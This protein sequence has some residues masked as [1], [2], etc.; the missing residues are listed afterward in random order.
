METCGLTEL[1]LSQH[2]A[3]SC[4]GLAGQK[5]VFSQIHAVDASPTI[6]ILPRLKLLILREI[7]TNNAS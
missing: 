5:L 2:L 3:A 7:V 6:A 4:G 1:T